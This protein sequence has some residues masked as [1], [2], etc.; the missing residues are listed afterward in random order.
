MSYRAKEHALQR[1]L[2]FMSKPLPPLQPPKKPHAH[3]HKTARALEFCSCGATRTGDGEWETGKDPAAVALAS[4]AIA[5]STPEERREK[6]S[7]GG[8]GRWK[9]K[10]A[11]QRSEFMSF[12]ASQPRPSRRIEDRCECG[13]YTREYAE[14]RG[15]L[16]GKALA[17]RLAARAQ[18]ASRGR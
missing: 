2:K 9:D 11:K 3:K 1:G 5:M 17:D 10:T 18:E 12:M 8:T 7:A 15:H 16:C 14:R 13:R 6:A 4:K